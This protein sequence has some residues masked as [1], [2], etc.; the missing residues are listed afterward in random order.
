MEEPKA[1]PPQMFPIDLDGAPK[2]LLAGR[3]WSIPKLTPKQA[4]HVVPAMMKIIGLVA[5]VKS[6]VTVGDDGQVS[7][8]QQLMMAAMASIDGETFES[9][10]TC[11]FWSLKRGYPQLGQGEFDEMPVDLPEM[12]NALPVIMRQIGFIKPK[13]PGEKPAGEES[14]VGP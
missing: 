8:D 1:A 6:A 12:L 7:T 2:V 9:V 10:A 3:E 14:A 13:P 4:R 11:I 5:K